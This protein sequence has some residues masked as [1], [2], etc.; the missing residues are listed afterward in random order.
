MLLCRQVGLS[1]QAQREQYSEEL[2]Q[3]FVHGGNLVH[4]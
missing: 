2:E 4:A 1:C 3:V